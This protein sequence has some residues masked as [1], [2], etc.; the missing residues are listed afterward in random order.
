M[1]VEYEYKFKSGEYRP[2]IVTATDEKAL[3]HRWVESPSMA[4]MTFALVE[5]EDGH[6]TAVNPKNI[7][8]LDSR[9]VFSDIC[10]IMGDEEEEN[11]RRD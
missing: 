10:W 8:F 7:R 4:G 9:G 6:V 1:K 11:E 2:C 3:F 5:F